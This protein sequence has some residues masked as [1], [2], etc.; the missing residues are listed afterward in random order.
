MGS[1]PLI[2]LFYLSVHA[3]L[4]R[5]PD[6]FPFLFLVIV[7]DFDGNV[8]NIG[9]VVGSWTAAFVLYR[10]PWC[11]EPIFRTFEVTL[12]LIVGKY[13]LD[14]GLDGLLIADLGINEW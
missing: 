8:L 1:I 7:S 11:A 6:V 2:M 5:C 4:Y 3:C 12:L 13:S 14:S 9:V 10:E